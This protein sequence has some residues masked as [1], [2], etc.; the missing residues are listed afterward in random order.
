[1]KSKHPSGETGVIQFELEQLRNR[2]RALDELI[3]CLERYSTSE[4]RPGRWTAVER[5]GPDAEL[6]D[7]GRDVA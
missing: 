2:K 4:I 7:R 5:V 1:M 6:R 3:S